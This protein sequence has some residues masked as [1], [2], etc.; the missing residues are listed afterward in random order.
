MHQVRRKTVFF[1]KAQL[2]NVF[3]DDPGGQVKKMISKKAIKFTAALI[4]VLTVIS[5][6]GCG[7]DPKGGSGK[8]TGG[9]TETASS[10]PDVSDERPEVFSQ[11]EYL[12][13]QNVFYA[14]YG[15]E[16]D[17]KEVEK[18]G[19]FTVL[20]DA[21]KNR[22]RFYVWGYYD[23]T[24]CCDWQWEF[25]PKDGEE[26]PPVG[27]LVT[28]KGTFKSSGDAL[29]GYW[30]TDPEVKV[31]TEY[32]GDTAERDMLSMSG[33]LERVQIINIM[34][35]QDAFEGN[36]FSAYGRV[37]SMSSIE[38]PYY[39]GSWQID[40]IWDG[41]LPAIGTSVEL[42]GTVKEGK[43]LVESIKEM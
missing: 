34:N 32:S 25:V 18:E 36:D 8:T 7:S 38:D 41:E 27:S 33:T 13:Y 24:R 10:G 22:Q 28:V 37:A 39:N 20:Y 19:I 2:T 4:A 9:G 26:L 16:Q 3:H 17:G 23:Q 14:D 30:I 29:D 12:L 21:Y 1:N 40:I 5:F 35:R 11:D 6:V 42:H 43:L 31:K 15:K